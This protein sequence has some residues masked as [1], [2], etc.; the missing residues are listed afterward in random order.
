[1]LSLRS[2]LIEQRAV[3]ITI[4]EVESRTWSIPG[5][6]RSPYARFVV[7]GVGRRDK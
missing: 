6:R 7:R 5:A 3:L 4:V 2:Q 1:M